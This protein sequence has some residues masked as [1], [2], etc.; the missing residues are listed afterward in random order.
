MESVNRSSYQKITLK[1]YTMLMV[2][3]YDKLC[4]ID[5]FNL[6]LSDT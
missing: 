6:R 5:Y 3:I 2:L 4:Y 1:K